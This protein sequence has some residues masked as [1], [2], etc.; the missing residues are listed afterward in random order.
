MPTNDIKNSDIIKFVFWHQIVSPH[1]IGLAI[2]L[3][4]IGFDV[5]YVAETPMS[6]ERYKQGWTAPDSQNIRIIYIQNET[7]AILLA[8]SFTNHAI[9]IV[10]GIR[11][12]GYINVVTT[13]LRKKNAR[14]GAIMEAI[15]DRYGMYLIKQLIYRYKLQKNVNQPDFILAIGENMPSWLNSCG[16]PKNKIFSF[17]Y[18]IQSYCPTDI[19]I[20]SFDFKI[21]FIGQLIKRKRLDLLINA[22]VKLKNMPYKLLIIGNGILNDKLKDQAT[23]LLGNE[24]FD[25]VGTIQMNKIP[26]I[27]RTLDCLV[28]PSDHD[29]WG[30]VVSEA[31]I[32]GTPVIC[33]D[34]CGASIAVK[35]SS[36]GGVFRKGNAYELSTLLQKQISHGKITK[37]KRKE[38]SNWGKCLNAKTGADYLIEI[39]NYVYYKG[40]YPLTPWLKYSK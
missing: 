28:L 24:R 18:F 6:E 39:I 15:D 25:M 34:A 16:Y 38:L 40:A 21:G 11:G 32:N 9:H 20:E 5:T 4:D 29:G 2:N 23:S 8:N 10:Q 31:L 14:L 22:L 27:M 19:L 37:E 26:Y 35:A 7:D 12:N 33:S 30:V 3:A 1:M 17:A 13:N 36:Q